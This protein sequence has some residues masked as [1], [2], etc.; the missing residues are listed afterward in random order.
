MMR[1]HA[2]LSA[3]L[4]A[5]FL[6]PGM[7][8]ASDDPAGLETSLVRTVRALE[9]L[10]GFEQRVRTRDS[11]VIADVISAT[12]PAHLAPTDGGEA[13]D[14]LRREVSLLQMELDR[15]ETAPMSDATA[16]FEAP[17]PAPITTGLD[18][19]TRHA[20]RLP[21]GAEDPRATHEARMEPA[22][23]PVAMER[24]GYSADPLRHALACLRA[25]RP[26]RA[27]ELLVGREDLEALYWRSRALVELDRVD[28]AIAL[29]TRVHESSGDD[30]A[31]R[32]A[33]TDLEFLRWKK[34]FQERL[35][36]GMRT[37]GKEP[38]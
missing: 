38:R 36:Q 37:Q 4:A 2:A 12:E 14:K 31:G 30:Y 32:R 10:A 25:G 35:P 5:F 3:G 29:L 20:L 15:L 23:A 33:A 8:G 26:E 9:T 6:L 18:E 27:L 7:R 11:S 24:A 34:D 19:S 28:D 16:S 17:P 1:M 13:L 21:L 22:H